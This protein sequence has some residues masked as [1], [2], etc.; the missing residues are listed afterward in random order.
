[1]CIHLMAIKNTECDL[2]P[3]TVHAQV[4]LSIRT[5]AYTKKKHI[6]VFITLTLDNFARSQNLTNIRRMFP[7]LFFFPLPLTGKPGY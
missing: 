3:K 7:F 2:N 1:M 5:A 4:A 6:S